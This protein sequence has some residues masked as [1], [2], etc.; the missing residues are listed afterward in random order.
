MVEA[1][2]DEHRVELAKLRMQLV[3]YRQALIDAGV[4]PPDRDGEEL[5]E[6]WR[7]C[8]AV[9][10]TASHFTAQLRSAKELL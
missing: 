3:L 2:R 1:I 8:R 10:T 6:M 5:M 9:I 4:D 7:D